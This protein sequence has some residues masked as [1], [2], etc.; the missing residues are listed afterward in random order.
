MIY[1][2]IFLHYLIS[3]HATSYHKQSAFSMNFWDTDSLSDLEKKIYLKIMF[4]T[5]QLWTF[6]HHKN[7]CFWLCNDCYFILRI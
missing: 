7:E 2:Q 5:L 1:S 3:N 4:T 6:N